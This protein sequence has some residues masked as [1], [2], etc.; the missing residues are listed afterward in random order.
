M[1]D[2]IKIWKDH[3]EKFKNERWMKFNK[4]WKSTKKDLHP[5]KIRSEGL[6]YAWVFY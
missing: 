3:G 4:L 2:R 1:K 6:T 5:Y